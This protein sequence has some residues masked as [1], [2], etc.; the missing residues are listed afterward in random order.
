GPDARRARMALDLLRRNAAVQALAAPLGPYRVIGEHDLCDFE[1]WPNERFKL[2]LAPPPREFAGRTALV[3]G[4]ASGIGRACG[5]A[6][7]AA[8]AH[9]VVADLDSASARA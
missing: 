5:E 2:T 8:G 6:L 1:Y 3:T 4:G 7:A 9:V